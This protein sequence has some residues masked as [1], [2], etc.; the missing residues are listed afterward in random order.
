MYTSVKAFISDWKYESEATLKLL[1]N[2]TDKSLGQKVWAEGRTLGF[3]AWHVTLS[4]GEMTTKIGLNPDCPPEDT[5]MPTKAIDIKNIY[6]KAS[7]SLISELESKLKDENL[8]DEVDAY[9]QTFT[10]AQML[11]MLNGHQIHHRGQMTVLMRQAGLKVPGIYGPSKE[12]WA[13][14]GMDAPE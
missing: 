2:L 14:Y 7:V 5:K 12:E 13:S 3:L 8:N 9:G 6:E 11:K 4:I 1:N 10:K